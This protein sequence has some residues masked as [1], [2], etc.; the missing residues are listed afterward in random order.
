MLVNISG[1][2]IFT[3]D[4]HNGAIKTAPNGSVSF[5]IENALSIY[6]NNFEVMSGTSLGVSKTMLH[7]KKWNGR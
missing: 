6:F 4:K 7:A 3:E 2:F 5:R 1:G